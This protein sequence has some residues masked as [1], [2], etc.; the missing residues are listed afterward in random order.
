M[1]APKVEVIPEFQYPGFWGTTAFCAVAYEVTEEA[2]HVLIMELTRN[3]GTSI[4]NAAEAV[5]DTLMK[6]LA[7]VAQERPIVFWEA[8]E[9]RVLEG[10]RAGAPAMDR[11]TTR[12]VCTD[13]ASRVS[14][15]RMRDGD[16]PIVERLTKALIDAVAIIQ[17]KT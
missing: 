4:T 6:H 2:V 13:N 12:V 8:Y 15:P 16:P 11:L 17:P 1:S 3:R 10:M 9:Y 7:P 5:H 14:W